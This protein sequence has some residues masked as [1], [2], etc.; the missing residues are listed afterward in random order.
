MSTANVTI[1]SEPP[2]MFRSVGPTSEESVQVMRPVVQIQGDIAVEHSAIVASGS[3]LP[4]DKHQDVLRTLA[5]E[6][7]RSVIALIVRESEGSATVLSEPQ[8]CEQFPVA[9]AVAVFK[10]S[11]GWEEANPFSVSMTGKE[12]AVRARF[13]GDTWVVSDL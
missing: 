1:T 13:N 10:A 5:K 3:S 11:W 9:A 12:I 6:N 7:P 8:G 4:D 2:G